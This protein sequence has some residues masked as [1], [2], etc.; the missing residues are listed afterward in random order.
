MADAI[1][2]IFSG[3]LSNA[4]KAF[5][6]S[7]HIRDIYEMRF[8]ELENDLHKELHKILLKF[9]YKAFLCVETYF[10]EMYCNKYEFNDLMKKLDEIQSRIN[11]LYLQMPTVV[12][13]IKGRM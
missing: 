2:H 7:E 5:H 4:G 8:E 12:Q 3:N 13:V 11:N 9:Q 10:N 1:N 6:Q